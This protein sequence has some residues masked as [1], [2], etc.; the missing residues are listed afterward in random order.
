MADLLGRR[1]PATRAGQSQGTPPIRLDLGH[2]GWGPPHSA[3]A[4][5]ARAAAEVPCANY[6]PP[7]GLHTLRRL[8]A[9]RHSGPLDAP[10]DPASVTITSGASTALAACIAALTDAAETVLCPDPGYPAFA[11]VAHAMGRRVALYDAAR[12]LVDGDVES[13]RRSITSATRLVIWNSPANP[14]GAVAA[15]DVTRSVADIVANTGAW[16]LSDE[17]YEDIVFSGYHTSPMRDRP[18]QAVALHSMS[19]NYGLAGWRVG[20]VIGPPSVLPAVTRAHWTLAMSASGIAQR[21]AV[22]ALRVHPDYPASQLDDLRDRRDI[23]HQNLVAGGA[24]VACPAGA[25]FLWVD[26]RPTELDGREFAV[27]CDAEC[28]VHVLDGGAFGPRGRRYVR[29]TFSGDHAD[30]SEGSRRVG[31]LF[32][33]LSGHRQ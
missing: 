24:R 31:E 8:L 19:K 16:L 3:R 10:L 33:R 20:Y 5:I 21:A 30:V 4:A 28:G 29:L 7:E 13:F 32:G 26:V 9:E 15:R 12:L 2:P 25:F 14:L 1:V 18:D 27:A 22:A 11:A 6:S 17:V 23:A